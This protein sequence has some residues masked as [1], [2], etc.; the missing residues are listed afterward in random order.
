MADRRDILLGALSVQ[1]GLVDQPTLTRVADTLIS[2]SDA[3]V[4][5]G[6]GLVEAGALRPEERA[7][8]DTLISGLVERRGG[9]GEALSALGGDTF[10]H[11]TFGPGLVVSSDGKV[12]ARRSPSQA[13]AEAA[14]VSAGESSSGAVSTADRGDEAVT[15]EHPERYRFGTELGRGG[16]G[17]VR[18]AADR[19]LG[20]SVAVKELLIDARSSSRWGPP[21]SDATHP[22]LSRFLLEARV[23]AQLEHPNIVPVHELGR[24][25]DGTVYYTMKRVR[26]RTLRTALEEAADLP[27]RLRLLGHVGDLCQA[28]AY[29]HA[30]G[31]IHRD[32]KPD[33]V[34]L[35]EFGET[36]VLDWG[37]AKV[38]GERDLRGGELRDNLDQLRAAGRTDTVRGAAMGTPAYM[39]PE[40]ARGAIEDVDERSDVWSLGV[41]LYQLV[42]GRLPFEAEHPLGVL[43]KV[44]EGVHPDAR[45]LE[46][47]APPELCAV[48]RRAMAVDRDARYDSAKELADEIEAFRSGARVRAHE[49]SSRELIARFLKRNRAVVAVA[50]LAL[51]TLA[52]GSAVAW[53][54]IVDERDRALEAERRG[55][56]SLARVYAERARAARRDHA[57]T[58]VELNAVRALGTA[59]QPL[60]RGLL[61][62]AAGRPRPQRRWEERT[63][64]GCI[65]LATSPDGELACATN[66][67][68]RRWGADDGADRELVETSGGWVRQ[69]AYSA[70]GQT[71][72]LG[73]DDGSVRVYRGRARTPAG[74]F[75]PLRGEVLSLAVSPDGEAVGA[76]GRDGSVAFWDSSGGLLVELPGEGQPAQALAISPSRPTVVAVG[77][78]TGRIE[79][80]D[81][82]GPTL[83]RRIDAHLAEVRALAFSPD[84]TTLASGSADRTV[85]LWRSTRGG[86]ADLHGHRD[87]VVALAFSPDGRWLYSGAHDGEVLRWDARTGALTARFVA[88]EEGLWHLA[89]D[90]R[91]PRL[92]TAGR[93]KRVRAWDTSVSPSLARSAELPARPRA[94]AADPGGAHLAVAFDDRVRVE[95]VSATRTDRR[96]HAS[97]SVVL[98]AVVRADGAPVLGLTDGTVRDGDRF[99]RGHAGPVRA[100]ALAPDGRVVSGGDD[101]TIRIWARTGTAA[102]ILRG[103]HGAV[104]GLSVSPDGTWLGSGGWDKTARRWG[105]ED[106][107][108]QGRPVRHEDRVTAVLALL[109]GASLSGDATGELWIAEA[110]GSRRVGARG[111]AVTGLARVSGL[112]WVGRADGTVRGLDTAYVERVVLPAHPGEVLAVVAGAGWLATV[113]GDDTL[114]VW[115]LSDLMVEPGAL[116]ARVKLWYG[117]E[118]E[119][120]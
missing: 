114:A 53:V 45:A 2:G 119:S 99:L 112:A 72:A 18:L 1:L 36:L 43:M 54:N 42:T 3:S 68:V 20:R 58:E 95:T 55:R 83:V 39:S 88:H 75:G 51:L 10:V 49:Y 74:S 11:D 118:P 47:E 66:L 116:A 57:W 81:R 120:R 4:D 84:G 63:W 76:A 33:N 44:T 12:S 97:A 62:T 15:D 79:V 94:L 59:D 21:R 23:T 34:M 103:H 65:R 41:V 61:L 104:S 6:E 16:I 90:P 17:R 31:V 7:V 106:G 102:R 80:W 48:I 14:V 64:A 115:D 40:Q 78:D 60:A 91:G 22:I 37:L 26:G 27:A 109:G 32:I 92:F 107:R 29:A 93:D 50:A 113:G 13:E 25:P 8:L 105:L 98:T 38:R 73:T 85:T 87:D 52:I 101:G 24:R 89:H 19:H 30:R 77:Q 35:G 70:D 28:I 96:D 67:G 100:L 56:Q 111:A 110:S 86:R 117:A 108:E 71:L 46:P 5:L 9:E 82:S 69:V